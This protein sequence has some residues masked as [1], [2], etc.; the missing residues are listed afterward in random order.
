MDLPSGDRTLLP[1]KSVGADG[2]H[3]NCHAMT[4][5]G[6]WDAD[7]IEPQTVHRGLWSLESE[8]L[9]YQDSLHG[10]HDGGADVGEECSF[11]R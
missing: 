11:E 10:D 1:P 2:R 7:L 4:G 9:R 3:Q 5:H 6:E 8:E